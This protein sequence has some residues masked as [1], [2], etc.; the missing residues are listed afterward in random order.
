MVNTIVN[1]ILK[2]IKKNEQTLIMF[3]YNKNNL[4]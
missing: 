1:I 2:T 4:K 3:I